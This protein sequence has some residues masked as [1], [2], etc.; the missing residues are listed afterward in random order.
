MRLATIDGETLGC[1]GSAVEGCY[2][3]SDVVIDVTR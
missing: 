3:T 2:V 1:H